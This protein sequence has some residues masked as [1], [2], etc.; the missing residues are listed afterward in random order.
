[1][2]STT[3]LRNLRKISRLSEDFVEEANEYLQNYL[4]G[5]EIPDNID[6]VNTSPGAYT[7][8]CYNNSFIKKIWEVKIRLDGSLNF[9]QKGWRRETDLNWNNNFDWDSFENDKGGKNGMGFN[10]NDTWN[11]F[12]NDRRR[13]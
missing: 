9:R 10:W 2:F 4:S 11:Y 8:I 12:E 13:C 6:I 7:V 1:M 5:K 3:S